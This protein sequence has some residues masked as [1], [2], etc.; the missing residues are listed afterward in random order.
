MALWAETPDSTIPRE[1][2]MFSS[3]LKEF[4]ERNGGTILNVLGREY[5][6]HRGGVD[7]PSH[8]RK[9]LTHTENVSF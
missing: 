3:N 7:D 6:L 5:K 1:F 8:L 9:V 4:Q 2:A